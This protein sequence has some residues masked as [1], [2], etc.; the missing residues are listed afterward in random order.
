MAS[1]S[2][3]PLDDLQKRYR[4]V[5]LNKKTSDGSDSAN[6]VRMQRQQIE[7]LKK[8][9]DRLKED[10]ALETRQAKQA[11]NMSASAQIAK[12][13]DQAD[14]YNRK[15]NQERMRIAELKKQLAEI[16]LD[17]LGQ[18]KQMG[19]INAAQEAGHHVQRQIK[20]RECRLDKALVKYNE[21][22]A[23]NTELG[24]VISNLRRERTVFD[25]IHK[26]LERELTEK[27][28]K[29]AEI[30]D[31]CNGAYEAR[32]KAHLQ[33]VALKAEADRQREK[34]EHQWNQLDELIKQDSY[35]KDQ[36][37]RQDVDEAANG[38]VDP[39]YEEEARLR[40]QV[41]K[42]YE[43]I[44]Q[45]KADIHLCMEKV[46]SYEEAFAKIQKATCIVDID[47]LVSTFTTA[48]DQNFQLFNWSNDLSNQSEVL[49]V[50]NAQLREEIKKYQVG[51]A[52]GDVRAK[53]RIV[54]SLSSTL[55]QTD[56]LAGKVEES[57]EET[58]TATAALQGGIKALFDSVGCLD[59]AM[60]EQMK[61][62]GVTESNMTDFMSA[63][64][65]RVSTLIQ[66]SQEEQSTD[67]K[68]VWDPEAGYDEN[69]EGDGYEGGVATVAE[70]E[71][72]TAEPAAEEAAEEAAEP[73]A[74]AAAEPVAA[75]VAPAA[76]EP[77][78]AAEAPAAEEPAAAAAE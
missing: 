73:A 62:T 48:E 27:K 5:E 41:A 32:D 74:E 38:M 1:S 28:Q 36:S 46:Q 54:A 49:E 77:A 51:G 30:I 43:S 25:G 3:S 71:E 60:I 75:E 45:S 4:E 42:G 33:M 15:T 57:I 70:G 66:I 18:R 20:I 14:A 22:T 72:P 21:A 78:A 68:M 76:E 19:G 23:H 50:K 58:T 69:G 16:Q 8:D 26:K 53:K 39:V 7:K 61:T 13:Q 6:T 2:H 67:E 44:A 17:L 34:F 59:E 12:L 9:N 63:I 56:N 65:D 10:L 40:Q 31:I 29:M 55:G 35:K 47:D 52:E 37:M 64:E 24:H 11:N